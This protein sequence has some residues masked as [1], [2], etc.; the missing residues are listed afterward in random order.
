VTAPDETEGG[1]AASSG[2]LPL[3]HAAATLVDS[4][5]PAASSQT[6]IETAASSVRTR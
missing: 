4:S 5:V 6:V 3:I 1:L 2:M